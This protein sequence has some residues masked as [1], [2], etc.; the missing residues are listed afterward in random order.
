MVWR[1]T[2]FGFWCIYVLKFY[3]ILHKYTKLRVELGSLNL[4]PWKAL[5]NLALEQK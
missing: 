4:L 2:C 1:V 5:T 3:C